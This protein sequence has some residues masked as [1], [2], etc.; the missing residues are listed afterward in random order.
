MFNF[1]KI[2][3]LFLGSAFALSLLLWSFTFKKDADVS[4][5]TPDKSNVIVAGCWVV[6]WIDG[7]SVKV[8]RHASKSS[9]QNHYEE[10]KEK[11][12]KVKMVETP[13]HFKYESC[14]VVHYETQFNDLQVYIEEGRTV[15]EAKK[16]IIDKKFKTEVLET[17]CDEGC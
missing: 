7:G 5:S 3:F 17:F 15:S 11:G 4:A 16:K 10:Q 12:R 6:V 9:A 2:S 14:F 8:R 1:K 13:L